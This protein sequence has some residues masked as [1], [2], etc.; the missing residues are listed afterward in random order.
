M[1]KQTWLN[2][3]CGIRLLSNFINVDVAFDLKDLKE[4]KGTFVNAEID[5]NSAFVKADMRKLPFKD[6]SADYIISTYSIEHIPHKDV[7]LALKEWRRVLKKGGTIVITT[8]NMD[9]IARIWM[10]HISNR[11]DVTPAGQTFQDVQGFIYGNQITSGESHYSAF[12][13]PAMDWYI[14]AAG[15]TNYEIKV[16]P[17]GTPMPV[18]KGYPTRENAICLVEHLVVT[19]I[20]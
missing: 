10:A 19:A 2:L 20:K 12:N 13:P 9:E 14:K 8:I 3:G 11:A 15:F 4:K 7:L 1:K 5:K 6:N 18:I 16:Y 17:T